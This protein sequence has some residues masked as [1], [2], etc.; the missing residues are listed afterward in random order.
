MGAD[1]YLLC[2]D[3]LALLPQL[4][5]ESIDA[6]ITDPPYAEID[7]PY[8]RWTEAEWFDLMRPIVQE[9]R[10]ILK[11]SGS[12]VFIIQPNQEHVGRTRSWP[13]RFAGEL[14]QKWNIVQDLYWW[15]P[16]APPTIHCQ[17][18]HG[19]TRPSVK[20]IVW[21]GSPTCFRNQDR[22]LWTPSDSIRALKRTARAGRYCLP[23]GQS[24]NPARVSEIVEARGGVTPFNLIPIANANSTTS[25]GA[26]GHGAATPLPLCL[27]L[28]RYLCPPGG[29]IL[30]PFMGS[31]TTGIAALR[32]G[33]RFIGIERDPGY[34]AIAER[35]IREACNGN[36]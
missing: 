4:R 5:S 13:Y 6:V 3:S 9:T 17:A 20:W 34:Y 12:A 10:R 18:R 26:E 28:V 29:I 19:L 33:M 23:S 14:A 22:V 7:R 16:T 1:R 24:M 25:G 15:N 21:C 2:G 36:P 11:P 27:W 35:R 32:E 30:D 8:G 31:G